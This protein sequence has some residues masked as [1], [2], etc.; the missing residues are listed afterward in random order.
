V[1]R[2]VDRKFRTRNGL[3]CSLDLGADCGRQK[4]PIVLAHF[5]SHELV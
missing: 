1:E 5:L 2:I 3:R 4:T